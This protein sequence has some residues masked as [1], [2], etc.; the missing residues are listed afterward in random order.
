MDAVANAI[1]SPCAVSVSVYVTQQK[2]HS[3]ITCR[4]NAGPASQTAGQHYINIRPDSHPCVPGSWTIYRIQ[5]QCNFYFQANACKVVDTPPIR[6]IWSSSSCL[7]YNLEY[8]DPT[9]EICYP[10][11]T[12]ILEQVTTQQTQHG[13]LMLV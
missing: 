11:D 4:S 13:D 1:R 2:P 9:M 6:N 8:G 3:G 5:V 7:G 10:S 12:T